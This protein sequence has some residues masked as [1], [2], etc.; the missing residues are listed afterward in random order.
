MKWYWTVSCDNTVATPFVGDQGDLGLDESL[1]RTGRLVETWPGTAWVRAHSQQQDGEPDDV[2]QTLFALPIFSARLRTAL[3]H[4]G[5][6]GVEYLPIRVYRPNGDAIF[7]FSIANILS[8][9][10]AL[11]LRLSD[12][13]RL[14]DD[15]FLPERRGWIRSISK[16]VLVRSVLEGLDVIR[17]SCFPPSV[18]VSE[19]FVRVFEDGRFT[20]YS[21]HEVQT[22]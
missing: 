22:S 18:Y 1:L 17:L 6:E 11:D 5:I 3:Q 12:F 19:R 10:E 8:C 9:V 13:Q 4:A 20:G 21:F 7:G 2:L 16:P 15:Y 14:P